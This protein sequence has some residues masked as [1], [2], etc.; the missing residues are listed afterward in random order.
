MVNYKKIVLK[1]N[2][3]KKCPGCQKHNFPYKRNVFLDLEAFHF[4]PC[5]GSE[6]GKLQKDRP[7]RQLHVL[8][9]LWVVLGRLWAVLG[10][11]WAVLDRL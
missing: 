11:L 6:E 3:N 2:Y 10:R 8:G 5:E 7:Q 9:R 4:R 1:G